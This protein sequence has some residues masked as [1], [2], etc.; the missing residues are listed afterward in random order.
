MLLT[1]RNGLQNAK[2]ARFWIRFFKNLFH[3]KTRVHWWANRNHNVHKKSRT[4]RERI[5]KRQPCLV[6]SCPRSVVPV[7]TCGGSVTLWY[8]MRSPRSSPGSY[9]W[10]F[11]P[12]RSYFSI[13]TPY[14][15]WSSD[16]K[17]EN[18]KLVKGK[19]FQYYLSQ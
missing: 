5:T 17:Q 16:K 19:I 3:V 8:W 15:R 1:L 7:P 11:F 2:S 12:Q 6:V 10:H 18:R 13:G 14:L 4:P 9:S